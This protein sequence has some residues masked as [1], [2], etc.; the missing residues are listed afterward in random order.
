MCNTYEFRPRNIQ[1]EVTRETNTRKEKWHQERQ[2]LFIKS[3]V[4]LSSM[5][6][7]QDHAL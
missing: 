4:F 3:G 1:G 7:D 2:G 5:S 6:E